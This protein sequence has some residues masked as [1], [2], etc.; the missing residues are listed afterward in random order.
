MPINFAIMRCKKLKT[1]GSIAS[2]LQ[3]NFRERETWNADPKYTEY[4]QH[5]AAESTDEAMG[6]LRANLPDKVRANGVRC[7]EYMM[8]ASP[9]FWEK[10]SDAEKVKFYES[11]MA[12]LENKYGKQNIIAASI[13]RDET[14]PH[15][16]AFVTPIT[17]DG[18]LCARDFIGGREKLSD[19][20]STFAKRIQDSGLK[21]E[22]GI[23][24]SKAK[25]TTIRQYYHSL[26]QSEKLS[27]QIDSFK[28]QI[29][30]NPRIVKK[31]IIKNTLE[32]PQEVSKRIA[33]ELSPIFNLAKQRASEAAM[34]PILHRKQEQLLS[35]SK[36]LDARQKEI[37]STKATLFGEL[38]PLSLG[39]IEKI[40]NTIIEA[41]E[42][43]QKH[44]ESKHWQEFKQLQK[45]KYPVS[46]P[47][48]AGEFISKKLGLDGMPL[49]GY[50]AEK[51][52]LQ[53]QLLK[54]EKMQRR[55]AEGRSAKSHGFR[56]KFDR[57]ND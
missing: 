54:Q 8:T 12:W 33:G 3:H 39:Q 16:S 44:K 10:A 52:D 2:A 32:T 1:M 22:R 31:G 11:S 34:T 35:T 50:G 38:M 18:R 46:D 29:D 41:Q 23:E 17:K 5:F 25:H 24:G 28:N 56:F 6:A 14:S 15:I 21:L 4:N 27:Q 20:Q 43:N 57:W 53:K 19:D 7:V 13:H 36:S 42:F 49:H 37:E 55:L 40:E 45:E 48:K 9:E 47:N 51:R 26:N 30:P